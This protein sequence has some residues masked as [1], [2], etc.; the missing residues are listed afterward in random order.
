MQ[1][2]TTP[3]V[4]EL[5]GRDFL[6]VPAV[7]VQAQV[8]HNNLGASLMPRDAITDDW[9][10]GWNN[11]PV[12]IHD[13]P[14]VRG[15]SVSARS[16]EILNMRGVGYVFH[17]RAVS[18]GTTQLKAEVWLDMARAEE[19]SELNIIMERLRAGE[20]V[21]LSTGFQTAVEETAGTFNGED[22]ERVLRP[23]DPDHLAI[24]VDLT[25]ACSV[26]DGCGLGV[27][28]AELIAQAER[29]TKEGNVSTNAEPGADA[30]VEQG[31][32][33]SLMSKLGTLLRGPKEGVVADANQ[34]EARSLLRWL[35]ISGMTNT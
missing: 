29:L 10:E 26:K 31:K 21:E 4:E 33:L 22:F 3:R 32:V 16:P 35:K 34:N 13:H 15:V 20:R 8:L 28:A 23:M 11:I 17:A 12:V 27:N 9:A 5:M 6:V 1:G 24:F 7:L 30:P 19:V 14:T 18:N 25:G 2:S